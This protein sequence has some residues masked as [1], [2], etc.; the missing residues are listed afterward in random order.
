ME[1]IALKC[2]LCGSEDVRPYGTSNGKKRYACGD[3]AFFRAQGWDVDLAGHLRR[4]GYVLGLCGGY[5]MLG[6]T[7]A[8]PLGLEGKP[9][10]VSG[11]GL[12]PVNTVLDADKRV[13]EVSGVSLPDST[14]FR[15]Y[16]IHCGRTELEPGAVPF[17]RRSDRSLDGAASADGHIAGCYVHRL[18]DDPA[19]RAYRLSALGA[20]SDGV[21]QTARVEAA[22]NAVA[23]TLAECLDIEGILAIA[24]S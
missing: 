7:I 17:L 6:K 22:L 23:A 18:F 1:T 9:A 19:Q 10:A 14:P 16:E 24:N 15:G 20:V 5:Q 8:D 12:L 2:P 11:L 3:L 13:T 4:G 21:D